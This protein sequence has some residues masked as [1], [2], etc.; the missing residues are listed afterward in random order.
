MEKN[1][2]TEQEVQN[3]LLPVRR[4]VES[5]VHEWFDRL[6]NSRVLRQARKC[7]GTT[8]E[9]WER[10]RALLLLQIRL[11]ENPSADM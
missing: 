7:R 11:P 8:P 6:G 9:G 10:L 1:Q 3:G 5:D 2:E 4:F